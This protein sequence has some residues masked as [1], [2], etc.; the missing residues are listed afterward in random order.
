MSFRMLLISFLLLGMSACSSERN[1]RNIPGRG[2][3]KT[4]TH[5]VPQDSRTQKSIT[6]QR[7]D[8]EEK[9][10]LLRRLEAIRQSNLDGRRDSEIQTLITELSG[11]TRAL[12][13][14]AVALDRGGVFK[15]EIEREIA[16]F[17]KTERE[18]KEDAA[19]VMNGMSGVYA[20]YALLA[21]MRFV[22]QAD[23][24]QEIQEIH[25]ETVS[26]LRSDSKAVE[27]AAAIAEACYTLSSMIISDIDSEGRYDK[28][29]EQIERQYQQ[30]A[31][32]AS[33]QEDVFINGMFRAYEVSQLWLLSINPDATDIISE[34]NAGVSEDSADATNVGMQ[35]GIAAKYLFL[36]SYL[37][38]KDTVNLTH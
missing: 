36:I 9:T 19:R 4:D 2:A 35:M 1:D 23:R 15:D 5:T 18:K 31:S 17:E 34:L 30:G 14:T 27:A 8:P 26:A 11:L 21:K 28:A 7:I 20:M 22:G 32:V 16:R 3:T 25:N 13:V 12:A 24:Q 33:K 10:I 6:G 37:I 29:F 38:A